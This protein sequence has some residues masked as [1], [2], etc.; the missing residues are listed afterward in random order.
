MR[1]DDGITVE[2]LTDLDETISTPPVD[3]P[4][5]TAKSKSRKPLLKRLESMFKLI[6]N[7]TTGLD[8]FDGELIEAKAAKLAAALVELANENARAKAILESM[9]EGGAWAGVGMVVT[10]EIATP[11]A[12]HHRI[13][14]EPVNSNLA[15]AL[16]IPLRER[17]ERPPASEG[18]GESLTEVGEDG[19]VYVSARD[20]ET[21]ELG[22]FPAGPD[23]R[24][25]F[26]EATDDVDPG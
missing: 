17:K 13:L 1:A 4:S 5:R 15:A 20:P 22:A 14:P 12:V 7:V 26:P 19:T 10:W 2:D 18:E 6:G 23:G 9:L 21:G 25:I 11:I 16:D 8:K 24:P 3:K